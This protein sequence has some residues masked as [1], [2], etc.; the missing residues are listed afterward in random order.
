MKWGYSVLF[1]SLIRMSLLILILL[2]F[3]DFMKGK[4]IYN[5]YSILVR[6]LENQ[7]SPYLTALTATIIDFSP[8]IIFALSS[9]NFLHIY[10]LVFI[11]FLLVCTSVY[12][13]RK[14]NLKFGIKVFLFQLIIIIPFG[15]FL[16]INFGMI[17]STL[18]IGTIIYELSVN[19]L[20]DRK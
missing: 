11:L 4:P 2:V 15:F 14:A 16:P 1:S 20:D 13:L 17:V 10:H 3:Y 5:D 9:P 19:N 7:E 12:I 6:L 8:I 18:L